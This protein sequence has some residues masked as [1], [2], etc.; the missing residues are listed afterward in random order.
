VTDSSGLTSNTLRF[1]STANGPAQVIASLSTDPTKSVTFT[2]IAVPNI[3]VTGLQISRG[4]PERDR[5]YRVRRALVVQLNA[6]NGVASGVPV[7]FSA[8]GPGLLS[9]NTVNTDASGQARVNITAG[10][11][12]GA[13]TVLA[14]SSGFSPDVHADRVAG[15]PESHRQLLL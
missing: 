10:G 4:T 6:A 2:A 5:Q 1:P 7:Q 12:Q 13:V 15:R 8:T 3:T 14:Q 9:A 11:T